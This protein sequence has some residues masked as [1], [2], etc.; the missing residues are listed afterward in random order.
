MFYCK[1]SFGLRNINNKIKKRDGRG[2]WGG[3]G[4]GQRK[5]KWE[6]HLFFFYVLTV[7]SLCESSVSVNSG[8]GLSAGKEG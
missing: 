1:I 2:G 6:I 7:G 8:C 5:K 3:E 4:I